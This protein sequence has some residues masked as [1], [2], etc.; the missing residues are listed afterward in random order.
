M[1]LVE[2]KNSLA[3]LYYEPVDFSLALSDFL[4]IDD[5][6]QKIIAQVISIES[7]NSDT[8]NCAVLKFALNLN[9]D[10]THSLYSGYVPPLDA[11]VS[12]TQPKII[13]SVFSDSKSGINL[14]N[15]VGSFGIHIDL[16]SD[17]MDNFLY[18][19]SDRQDEVNLFS[20]KILNFNSKY[21]RKTLV[22]DFDG[23]NNFSDYNT[24]R[25]GD[26]FKLPINNETINYIYENDL[27]GLTIE[28]KS[29]VQDILLEIQ[30]YINSI[31]DKF[32]PFDTLLSVV[33]DIYESD[34]SVGV[35]LLRNKLL[36]YKQLNIFASDID[37]ILSLEKSVD[38][39][40]VTVLDVKNVL[41]NWQKE[42]LNFVLNNIQSSYYLMLNIKD[43]SIEQD[44]IN[45]IYKLD[46]IRPI[47]FSKYDSLFAQQLK[48]FAKNLV[49]FR[50]QAYQKVFATYNSFLNKISQNEFIVSGDAT[51]YTPLIIEKLSE[52]IELVEADNHE[53]EKVIQTEESEQILLQA[54]NTG[55][56][57]NIE[58]LQDIETFDSIDDLPD[59]VSDSQEEIS[60][61]NFDN[62]DQSELKN[63]FEDSLEQEIAKDV[64]K[65]FYAEA[66][67][68]E[69]DLS[70][71]DNQDLISDNQNDSD[72]SSS[73]E[74]NY[75]SLFSDEDLDTLDDYNSEQKTD[76]QS[77][78][79]DIDTAA[80]STDFENLDD[81]PDI[82][83]IASESEENNDV[84]QSINSNKEEE[85]TFIKKD[86]NESSVVPVYSAD[87]PENSHNNV[88]IS[89]GNIVYHEKYGKG[90][91]EQLINY[92]N[93]T[94]CSIQFDNIG[95]RLLDPNLADLR[96]M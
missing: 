15:L 10:N 86:N 61:D 36:K 49:L 7:T 80:G 71:Q 83:S 64:D 53:T 18:I 77:D 62:N 74:V 35:I 22:V 44:S 59:L 23:L 40:L 91:V 70:E 56:A 93:K 52:N 39:N 55:M 13:Y 85:N 12:K 96:Q 79:I 3:K 82:E 47:I 94:L 68:P 30:E 43:D 89:E 38:S 67:I 54:D 65:M 25:L 5:G 20:E 32:I 66:A 33:N 9:A 11:L 88:K 24:L 16:K 37:E 63:I 1:K 95:R 92:G 51:Y 21:S 57:D 58:T 8:T 42:A 4:T 84:Q 34:K 60:V 19:Q 27:T 26:D 69:N 14:G 6:N 90:I 28:Q 48:S 75:D 41:S 73:S 72:N 45:L 87:I 81:L 46:N 2:I 76:Y 50:P 17:L 78:L 31:E 29:I